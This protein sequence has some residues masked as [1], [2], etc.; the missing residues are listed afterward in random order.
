MHQ[1]IR[2]FFTSLLIVLSL[3]AC[4]D[5]V[6]PEPI[7]EIQLGTTTIQLLLK[8]YGQNINPDGQL[9]ATKGYHLIFDLNIA[10]HQHTALQLDSTNFQ[11]TDASGNIYPYSEFGQIALSA[12]KENLAGA[13]IEAN[14]EKTGFLVFEV[15][16]Q[17]SY[18]LQFRNFGPVQNATINID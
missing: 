9:N 1:I 10:N 17:K 12:E 18:Q 11:L 6:K 16:E 13:S 4:N 8:N 3:A 15:P 7:R 14:S 5:A 2:S